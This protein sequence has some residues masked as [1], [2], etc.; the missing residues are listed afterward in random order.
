MSQPIK[1][2][3]RFDVV[4]VPFPFTDSSST[5][6]RPALIISESSAFNTQMQMSVMAM[7]TTATHQPWALDVNI[8]DLSSAG[9]NSSSIVRMK[10]FTLDHALI[11]RSIGHLAQVDE[12]EVLKSIGKLVGLNGVL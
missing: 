4:V 1:I 12:D 9:L 8:T 7:I 11:V 10:L 2:Y 3:S 5:K 6:R